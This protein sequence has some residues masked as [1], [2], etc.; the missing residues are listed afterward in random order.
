MH[1]DFVFGLAASTIFVARFFRMPGSRRAVAGR[2]GA[3][4]RRLGDQVCGRLAEAE[5]D[6]RTERARPT[7]D[8]HRDQPFPD[9]PRRMQRKTYERLKARAL[10]LE[11]DLPPKLRGKTV[12]YR[13]LVYYAP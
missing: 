13:N 3:A 5:G 1:G 8:H 2:L 10:N 11:M 7:V 6:G 4:G 12:D 9:R